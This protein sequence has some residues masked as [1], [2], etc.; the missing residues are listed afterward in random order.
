[1]HRVDGG[2]NPE[3]SVPKLRRNHIHA[4]ANEQKHTQH[5]WAVKQETPT[6]T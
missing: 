3:V 2:T 6:Y 5:I 1:M 4:T